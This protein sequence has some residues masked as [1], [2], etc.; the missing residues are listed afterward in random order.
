MVGL[1]TLWS[2]APLNDSKGQPGQKL[3]PPDATQLTFK[4]DIEPVLRKSCV[5]CHSGPKASGRYRLNSRKS[6]IRGGV[7]GTA[8]VPGRSEESLL[9]QVVADAVAGSEMPPPRQ[10]KRY[11]KLT[12]EQIEL[13][14]RWIDQGAQ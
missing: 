1:T 12:P 6:A 2:A 3:V 13:L 10:R 9:V 11:P 7:S 14:R 5:K 8:V 4:L